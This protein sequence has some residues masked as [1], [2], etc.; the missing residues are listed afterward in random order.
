MMSL[1]IAAAALTAVFMTA[2]TASAATVANGFAS[3][4]QANPLVIVGGSSSWNTVING[5]ESQ[6]LLLAPSIDEQWQLL[7]QDGAG[8]PGGLTTIQFEVFGTEVDNF[9]F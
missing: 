6:R 9:K 1:R 3:T 5:F 8:N 4:P 2:G 7:V